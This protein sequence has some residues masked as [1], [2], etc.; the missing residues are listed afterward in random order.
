MLWTLRAGNNLKLSRVAQST[1]PILQMILRVLMD[2][3]NSFD[4]RMQ[5]L[6]D[7]FS[8]LPPWTKWSP[9]EDSVLGSAVNEFF[10]QS[11][12]EFDL[13]R[14][15]DEKHGV[16]LERLLANELI[17]MNG[18]NPYLDEEDM[19]NPDNV[20]TFV[21]LEWLHKCSSPDDKQCHIRD[22]KGGWIS[23][24]QVRER[25]ND[26][27]ALHIPTRTMHRAKVGATMHPSSS[28]RKYLPPSRPQ[29]SADIHAETVCP[30]LLTMEQREDST[31]AQQNP[32]TQSPP[33]SLK[34]EIENALKAER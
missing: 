25:L 18:N 28:P 12:D 22:G 5:Q 32:I 29:S 4:S 2:T 13:M 15:D 23:D 7:L 17:Q 33:V 27:H 14:E 1:R 8:H 19:N 6:C 3:S 26:G 11:E 9:R 24:A 16:A 20:F 30:R 21:Y 31:R 34:T 10:E